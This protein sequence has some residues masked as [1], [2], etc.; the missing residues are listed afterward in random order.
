M[1]HGTDDSNSHPILSRF[2]TLL[3]V[4]AILGF[5]ATC[6][7]SLHW[8]ADVMANARIQLTL[9]ALLATIACLAVR[10]K[11]QSILAFATVLAHVASMSGQ[12]LGPMEKA[13]HGTSQI[14]LMTL[15][16]LTRNEE[17]E[18][19]VKEIESVDPDAFAV[20]EVNSVWINAIRRRLAA[21]Y[22]HELV[23]PEE[24]GNFGIALFSK[25]PIQQPTTFKLNEEIHSLEVVIDGV[26]IIA[27][28]PLPPIGT[29]GFRSRNTHFDRLAERVATKRRIAPSEPL[30][31]MGDLNVTPWSPIFT[32]FARNTEL[33]RAKVGIDFQPTWYAFGSNLLTGLKLDHV[34]ISDELSCEEARIGANV[35]SDHRS[36]SVQLRY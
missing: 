28:H 1:N 21:T 32:R 23:H 8:V 29:R 6:F 2:A 17:H 33:H 9:A 3:A 13:Q 30:V 27:T 14:R 31:L 19:V 26:R 15:N 16:V 7:A 35:G 24:R 10:Q 11:R 20:L 36:V 12:L 5:I 18:A 4:T 34:L 22:P 25:R